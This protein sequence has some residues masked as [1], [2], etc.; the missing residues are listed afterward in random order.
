[1]IGSSGGT[2]ATE[3]L[4]ATIASLTRAAGVVDSL[5]A[6]SGPSVELLDASLA[7]HKALV[8]LTDSGATDPGAAATPVTWPANTLAGN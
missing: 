8:A 7:I 4:E 2:E 5:C 1:M 3:T 6:T